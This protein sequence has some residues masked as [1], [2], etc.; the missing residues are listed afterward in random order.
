MSSLVG[1]NI[2]NGL[3]GKEVETIHDEFSDEE[4]DAQPLQTNT[5]EQG[6]DY[7]D[8]ELDQMQLTLEE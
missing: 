4:L 2:L 7:Y 6:M 8:N 3:V 5:A 1:G